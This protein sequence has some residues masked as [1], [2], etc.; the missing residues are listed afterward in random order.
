MAQEPPKLRAPSFPPPSA[1]RGRLK[2]VGVV[3]AFGDQ[4]ADANLTEVVEEGANFVG[5]AVDVV[6]VLVE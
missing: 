2:I 3:E 6:G 1:V 5:G 4:A